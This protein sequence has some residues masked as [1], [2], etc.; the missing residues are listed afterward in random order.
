MNVQR[1]TID[2]IALSVDYGVTASATQ[3]D[4]GPQFLRI[5]DIQDDRVDWTSVPYCETSLTE[6]T[7]A[8]LAP[9]DIV[10]ARTGATTG[11]SFLIRTCPQRAVFASYLIR[12]RPNP[13]IVEPRYLSWFFQTPDYWQQVTTNAS[14]TAQ[15]GVNASKLRSLTVPVHPLDEQRRIADILDKANAIRRKR[16]ETIAL[17]EELLHSAFL[18]MFGDPVT[19]PK[20]WPRIQLGDLAQIRR[21]ASPRP[22]EQ[23]IGGT[24]PW[25]KIGDATASSDIYLRSTAEYVTEDGAAKSVRLK[26][27]ALIVANSGVS[28]G[29]A[30]ILSIEGCIHDGWLAFEGFD[31]RLEKRYFVGL[32]N[33]LTPYFRRLAP[34][35][36]Q[37]NLN[38]GLMRAFDVPLPPTDLQVAYAQIASA[39]EHLRQ[40][41]HD[42]I[43]RAERMFESVASVAFCGGIRAKI[44]AA[45][46]QLAL[47]E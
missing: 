16:K 29:F 39:I 5:T 26:P 31:E 19:N 8:Q 22:I 46:T 18:E 20:G 34:E 9:G 44:D 36:T 35:G 47:F 32:V 23:F 33:I 17:T 6:E 21:G 3:V 15:P 43:S 7:S 24:V 30:R 27:G 25:I 28:L 11:K 42:A 2:E 14:G 10:F 37:P 38:T 1:L 12:V 4:V 41:Q 40:R 13:S 45:K